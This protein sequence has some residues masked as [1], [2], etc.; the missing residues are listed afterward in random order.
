VQCSGNLKEWEIKESGRQGE[1]DKI[2]SPP[3]LSPSKS[4]EMIRSKLFADLEG[5]TLPFEVEN[6][7][8]FM[9][10]NPQDFRPRISH[11]AFTVLQESFARALA[12]PAPP[13]RPRV[14]LYAHPN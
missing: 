6:P 13:G 4:Y 7:Q 5:E 14:L 2:L 9:G 11:S 8:P 12:H 10:L 1:G 3:L